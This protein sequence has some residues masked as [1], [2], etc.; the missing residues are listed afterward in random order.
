MSTINLLPDDYIKRRLSRRAN[1]L[2]TGLFCVVMVGIVAAAVVLRQAVRNT[3]EVDRRIQKE[4]EDAARLIQQMQQL[5]REKQK[6]CEKSLATAP[7]MERI[8]R[9]TLLAV[10][11]N[12]LP[13]GASLTS[14]ELETKKQASASRGD[15][16]EKAK[17][18]SKFA[19]V[20]NQRMV[21]TAPSIVTIRITGL[22]STDVEVAKFIANMARSPL[23]KSVD[24][25]Y[26]QEQ[27]L[28]KGQAPIRQFQVKGELEQNADASQVVGR[29]VAAVRVETA[30]A[31]ASLGD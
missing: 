15:S 22:A 30:V 18:Q 10:V 2:C 21:D 26:S 31:A 27:L 16:S 5:E 3:E 25:V 1:V 12:S 6:L 13:P 19:K 24:L 29:K 8:P 20:S 11:T 23:M 14:F 7:L 9:S 28:A 17:S 4:Y